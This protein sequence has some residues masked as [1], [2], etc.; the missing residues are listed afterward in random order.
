MLGVG[1]LS[2]MFTFLIQRS[3]KF[4]L[5]LHLIGCCHPQ[6]G[7]LV[8][9]SILELELLLGHEVLHSAFFR[10]DM[11]GTKLLLLLVLHRQFLFRGVPFNLHLLLRGGANCLLN[12]IELILHLCKCHPIG[13]R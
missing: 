2:F 3:L 1:K 10:C 7:F 12:T 6:S 4:E 5:G 8:L 9:E 13:V 11:L